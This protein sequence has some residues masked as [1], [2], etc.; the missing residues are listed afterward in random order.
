MSAI[1]V[2]KSCTFKSYIISVQLQFSGHQYVAVHMM[3]TADSPNA[4]IVVPNQ[5]TTSS[6][7]LNPNPN[8][9]P[10]PNPD[11]NPTKIFTQINS[12]HYESTVFSCF[13]LLRMFLA[14]LIILRN[15]TESVVALFYG[16]ERN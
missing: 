3:R 14:A 4:N 2:F 7:N 5:T 9:Y 1:S 15:G 12:V 16:T 6:C 11:Y 8:P 10:Y 13:L